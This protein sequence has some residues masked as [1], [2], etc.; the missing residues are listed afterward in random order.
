MGYGHPIKVARSNQQKPTLTTG[1]V[2]TFL[3]IAVCHLSRV[4][5]AQGTQYAQLI[6]LIEK[7][8]ATIW[9]KTDLFLSQ[10]IHEFELRSGKF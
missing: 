4:S 8:H 7:K 10:A 9:F 3:L 6:L 1:S 5:V 2:G